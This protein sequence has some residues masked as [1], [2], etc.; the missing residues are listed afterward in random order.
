[1]PQNIHK[2][3]TPI[4][5]GLLASD[6]VA[7]TNGLLYYNTTAGRFRMYQGGVFS[8]VGSTTGFTANRAI[9]S[10]GT[11][12]LVAS[13]TTA[14]EIGYLSGVTSPL[15][16]QID[17]KLSLA[18]GTMTGNIAMGGNRVTGLGA[19]AAA[20]DAATKQYVDDLVEGRKW[21]E[22][23]RVVSLVNVNLSS[24]PAS[25]DGVT[26]TSGDR[27]LAAG[28][29]TGSQNG[30]YVFNGTGNAATRAS[31]MNT[32]VE[33]LNASMFVSEG[34]YADTQW[35]CTTNEPIT[36]GTTS[37]SFVQSSGAGG[38]TAG[39]GILISGNTVS[40]RHDGEGLQFSGADLALEL[41]GGSLFKSA[42]G[43]RI[44]TGGVTS[45][46]IADDTI[47]N[48]DINSAAAIAYSK[49]AALTADRAL[50][51]N[52]SGFVS[53]SAT[54][55]TEIGYVSGVTSPI[56][57][58]I[59]GKAS[60]AL[61][62]LSTTSINADL[63]PSADGV[64]SIGSTTLGW[65]KVWTSS[66]EAEG[67]ALSLIAQSGFT[68]DA[69]DDGTVEVSI[70]SAKMRVAPIASRGASDSSDVEEE[71]KH[72]VALNASVG[73]PTA[74][75]ALGFAHADFEGVEISYKMKES[76]SNRVRIGTIRIGTNG[77]DTTITD[78]FA[79]TADLGVA[80]TVA[81]SG[82]NVEVRY[83]NSAGNAVTMR[84]D[85]KR[86]RA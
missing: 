44:A 63:L 36:L 14:T 53:V 75:A 15:Q 52:G 11:G 34:T 19:P 8:D 86:F 22:P 28:Q 72:S 27:F 65:L 66:I 82:A 20:A 17:G 62:N 10:D 61:D 37:L 49:L 26:L 79:E 70:T 2:F 13:A 47:V 43:L 16:T 1:M 80:W 76:T 29:T 56:Q 67:T 54:T 51:S 83:T 50:V 12:A 35:V 48:A 33:V 40:V 42:A 25:V 4:R 7:P 30:I 60:T 64:R 57:T 32:S 18:G 71:Y 81:I 39:N 5:V 85:V 38:I 84:A 58:Q 68:F 23:V 73:S 9:V 45:S 6:P 78:E 74:V 55:A 69:N 3:Q 77:T 41:D 46:H 59:N 31:D 24:M 21:K